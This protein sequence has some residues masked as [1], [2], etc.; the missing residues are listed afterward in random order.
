VL[1]LILGTEELLMDRLEAEAV[2]LR[3]RLEGVKL[4]DLARCD[5]ASMM[6]EARAVEAAGGAGAGSGLPCKKHRAH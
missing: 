4:R 6:E 3:G 5:N 2:A 1:F